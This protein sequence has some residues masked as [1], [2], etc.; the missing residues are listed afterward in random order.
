M[1]GRSR[2]SIGGKGHGPSIAISYERATFHNVPQPLEYLFTLGQHLLKLL[3]NGRRGFPFP[4]KLFTL[5]PFDK[6]VTAFENLEHFS[7]ISFIGQLGH[8][9]TPNSFINATEDSFPHFPANILS[10]KNRLTL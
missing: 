10:V 8:G 7:L 2:Y 1:K 3:M 9:P 4:E 5:I 6:D